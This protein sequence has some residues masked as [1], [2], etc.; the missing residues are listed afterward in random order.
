MG[1]KQNETAEMFGK[2]LMVPQ[3]QHVMKNT[4]NTGVDLSHCDLDLENT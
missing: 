2:L 4:Q 1:T 3:C